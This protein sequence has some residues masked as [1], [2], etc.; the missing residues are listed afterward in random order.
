MQYFTIGHNC[1]VWNMW[2]QLFMEHKTSVQHPKDQSEV[3]SE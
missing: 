3:L 1:P 2:L